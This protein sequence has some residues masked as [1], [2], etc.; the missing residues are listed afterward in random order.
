MLFVDLGL[1]LAGILIVAF[2]LAPRVR[3]GAADP[4]VAALAMAFLMGLAPVLLAATG[5]LAWDAWFVIFSSVLL[6]A[7]GFIRGRHTAAALLRRPDHSG[8][9]G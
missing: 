1:L 2:A 3:S 5:V 7:I 8:D 6:F 9:Q 4:T